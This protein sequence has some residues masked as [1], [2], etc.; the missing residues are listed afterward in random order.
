MRAISFMLPACPLRLS[1]NPLK[2]E[3]FLP[4]VVQQLMEE[5]KA[6]VTVLGTDD[7]W[8]GVTYKEDKAAVMQ[9]IADFKTKGV[10]PGLLWK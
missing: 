9:A 4:S 10:Y 6:K 2:C 3:F 8:Y 1:E 7:R 5:E